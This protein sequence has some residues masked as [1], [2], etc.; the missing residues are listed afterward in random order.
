MYK[1]V[2]RYM[3]ITI[4]RI[5]GNICGGKSWRKCKI[6]HIGRFKFGGFT[7]IH[8][9]HPSFKLLTHVRMD[10]EADVAKFVLKRRKAINSFKVTKQRHL[11]MILEKTRAWYVRQKFGV[12][13]LDGQ[14][15]QYFSPAN[16]S[17]YTVRV[18]AWVMASVTDYFVRVGTEEYQSSLFKPR[19]HGKKPVKRPLVG[20][21]QRT[22]H[23]GCFARASWW[24]CRP[25]KDPTRPCKHGSHI[26]HTQISTHLP[27]PRLCTC[28]SS[29]T[30]IYA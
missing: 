17:R 15:H 7:I 6:R 8:Q 28:R 30:L 11:H 3:Y 16:I 13:F 26:R 23:A 5:A 1:T 27:S 2:Y 20:M 22:Y 14:I 19:D 10:G 12:F 18:K 9:P 29:S 24:S 25:G 4:Y 21:R